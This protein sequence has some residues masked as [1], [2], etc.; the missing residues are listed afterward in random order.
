MSFND[1]DVALL[2]S[3][4]AR[5][6]RKDVFVDLVKDDMVQLRALDGH[7]TGRVPAARIALDKTVNNGGTHPSFWKNFPPRI[8]AELLLIW[9]GGGSEVLLEEDMARAI[10]APGV[11]PGTGTATFLSRLTDAIADCVA[12]PKEWLSRL[13]GHANVPLGPGN[14]VVLNRTEAGKTHQAKHL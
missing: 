4:L 3:E 12:S 10:F 9:V 1:D 7:W 5:V 14:V 13:P 8:D 11:G 2:H 6:G